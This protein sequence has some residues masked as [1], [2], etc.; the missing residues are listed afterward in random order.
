M[1]RWLRHRFGDANGAGPTADRR[2]RPDVEKSWADDVEL[3][4]SGSWRK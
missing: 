2:A 3:G 4:G 1:R